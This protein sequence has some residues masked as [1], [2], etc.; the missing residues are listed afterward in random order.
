VPLSIII[1]GIGEGPFDNMD[2]L[3]ADDE[4]LISSEGKKQ[5]IDNV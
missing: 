5:K 1:V 4:R 2:K 3:D